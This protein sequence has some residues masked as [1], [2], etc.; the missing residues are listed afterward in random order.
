MREY[1]ARLISA[2]MPRCTA[3]SVCRQLWRKG[4]AALA[5]Y[6]QAVEDECNG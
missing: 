5:E 2:G 1:V 3:V 6:V 4:E